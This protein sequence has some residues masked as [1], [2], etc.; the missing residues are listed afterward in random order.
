MRRWQRACQACNICSG[1][2]LDC[3]CQAKSTKA[4]GPSQLCVVFVAVNSSDSNQPMSCSEYI[5]VVLSCMCCCR[6]RCHCTK[7]VGE[8]CPRKVSQRYHPR[9]LLEQRQSLER[10]SL[11]CCE[12][13]IGSQLFGYA[14]ISSAHQTA[15]HL[16]TVI[17]D[18][19]A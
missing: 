14:G 19:H 10:R 2:D 17:I 16:Q 9:L 13:G 11:I 18:P 4:K 1:R 3:R 8:D 7:P 12:L 5:S 6:R 15:Q